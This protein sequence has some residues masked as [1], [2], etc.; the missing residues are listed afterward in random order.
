MQETY[1]CRS[2]YLPQMEHHNLRL[3]DCKPKECE[4]QA[5]KYVVLPLSL[6]PCISK[7]SAN[8]VCVST[9]GG[10]ALRPAGPAKEKDVRMESSWLAGNVGCR[11]VGWEWMFLI[12][13]MSSCCC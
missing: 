7:I 6:S 5:D 10:H 4:M 3:K 9:L 8:T 11:S 12:L 1:F 2:L 13:R